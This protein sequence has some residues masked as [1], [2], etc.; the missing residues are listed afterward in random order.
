MSL[1]KDTIRGKIGELNPEK[2]EEAFFWE[3][4]IE[5]NDL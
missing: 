3:R 2:Q 1:G 5:P 4:E